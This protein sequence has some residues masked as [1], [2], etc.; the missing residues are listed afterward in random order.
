M[1]SEGWFLPVPA[2]VTPGPADNAQA[3]RQIKHTVA[4]YLPTI[5]DAPAAQIT[6]VPVDAIVGEGRSVRVH[7]PVSNKRRLTAA[8]VGRGGSGR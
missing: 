8:M 3:L 1:S 5:T 4:G 7:I 6:E 2:A